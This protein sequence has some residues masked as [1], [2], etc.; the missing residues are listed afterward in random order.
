MHGD[1]PTESHEGSRRRLPCET[2]R[3]GPRRCTRGARRETVAVLPAAQNPA[4]ASKLSSTAATQPSSARLPTQCPP[5]PYLAQ[6]IRKRRRQIHT[7]R[8]IVSPFSV[9]GFIGPHISKIKQISGKSMEK[10]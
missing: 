5:C 10:S 6:V 9:N 1:A 8:R 2:R 4:I 3:S 7:R